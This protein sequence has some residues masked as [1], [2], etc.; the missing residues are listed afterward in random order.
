MIW[1][2]HYFWKHPC[3]IQSPTTMKNMDISSRGIPETKTFICNPGNTHIVIISYK[4]QTTSRAA[5]MPCEQWSTLPHKMNSGAV[6]NWGSLYVYINCIYMICLYHEWFISDDPMS[7][8]CE[9]CFMHTTSVWRHLLIFWYV[10]CFY[11]KKT[12]NT[13]H[14]Q[15]TKHLL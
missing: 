10:W 2:Y 14:A 9:I 15:N 5:P 4:Y 8:F 11:L 3:W 1:G 6:E 7:F 12:H 13:W